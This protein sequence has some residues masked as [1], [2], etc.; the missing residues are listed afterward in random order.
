M[1]RKIDPDNPTESIEFLFTLDSMYDASAS[2]LMPHRHC[3]HFTFELWPLIFYM[4]RK[5]SIHLCSHFHTWNIG[6]SIQHI[7]NSICTE[8]SIPCH[9]DMKGCAMNLSVEIW[10]VYSSLRKIGFMVYSMKEGILSTLPMNTLVL[11]WRQ[12]ML[13]CWI[14]CY[15]N[16]DDDLPPGNVKF[17]IRPMWKFGR[18]FPCLI[19]G[20]HHISCMPICYSLP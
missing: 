10:K 17:P 8:I 14:L 2:F 3:L 4:N 18:G 16:L 7:R 5:Y 11:T 19:L 1:Y 9:S 20:I 12:D 15:R 6:S 13:S